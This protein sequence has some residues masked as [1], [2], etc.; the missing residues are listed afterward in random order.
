MNSEDALKYLRSLAD[1][2]DDSNEIDTDYLMTILLALISSKSIDEI[3]ANLERYVT[4]AYKIYSML[5][6]R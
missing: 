2:S 4:L 5:F 1:E 3:E 6:S